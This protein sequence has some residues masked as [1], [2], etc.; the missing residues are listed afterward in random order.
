MKIIVSITK[1]ILTV[2]G[3]PIHD[4]FNN[5]SN[6]FSIK[7]VHLRENLKS[8]IVPSKF[9]ALTPMIFYITPDY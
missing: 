6:N 5:I 8:L 4:I 1:W 3:V 7:F 2:R 9:F